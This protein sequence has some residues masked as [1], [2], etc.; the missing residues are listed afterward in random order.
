MTRKEQIE[1]SAK[2][3]TGY[4]GAEAFISG[5]EWADANPEYKTFAEYK[6][7][8]AHLEIQLK[9]LEARVEIAEDALG[10]K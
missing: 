8:I 2:S 7:R 3:E 4:L 10:F 1:K 5:A 6:I 9:T